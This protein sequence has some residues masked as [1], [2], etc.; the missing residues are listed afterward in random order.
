MSGDALQQ[1]QSSSSLRGSS[2]GGPGAG[3][4]VSA[5]LLLAGD[6]VFFSSHLAALP[7]GRALLG[8]AVV[9]LPVPG[10]VLVGF[11]VVLL[12]LALALL[13]Q[14][15]G[16]AWA[17]VPGL[18]AGLAALLAGGGG[19]VAPAAALAVA[20]RLAAVPGTRGLVLELAVQTAA[21]L[22][23]GGALLAGL[24][25]MTSPRA[26]AATLAHGSARF[27]ADVDL[28]FSDL[29][30]GEGVPLGLRLGHVRKHPI[31]DRS[32]DHV[33]VLM[34]TGAGK[35]SGPM[36][37][38]LLNTDHP[39]L[40]IDPKGELWNLTAGWRAYRGHLAVRFAPQRGA[41]TCCW[42][43][44]AEIEPGDGEVAALSV[45]ADNLITYPAEVHGETH[46]TASARSLLR[47]LVLHVLYTGGRSS[48][49]GATL[50]AV[51]DLLNSSAEG[52]EGLFK[53]LAEAEHDV[54]GSF[55]W[56]DPATGAKTRT[57]PEVARLARAFASTPDRERGSIVSTLNRFLDLWGDPRIAGATSRSDWSLSLLAER[58]RPATVYVTVPTNE[59]GR[60]A[61][62]LRI[63]LALLAQRVT[64]DAE[65][66][67]DREAFPDRPPLLLVLDEFAALGRIPLLEDVLAFFRGYGV[68]VLLAVQDLAQL[69]RLYGPHHTFSA[70]CR[71]HLASA[72]PDVSTRQEISRRLGET[73]YVYRKTSRSGR[74]FSARTMVSQAEVRRPL[75][76]EGEIGALPADR[77]LISKAGYPPVIAEKL[78]YWQ[79]PILARRATLPVPPDVPEEMLVRREGGDGDPEEAE[80]DV[81]GAEEGAAS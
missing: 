25:R 72:T 58:R 14:P 30:S 64:A 81:G 17:P 61:P 31:T 34:T 24:H 39:A 59:L 3:I 1:L 28:R 52:Q 79:H 43:P 40:V 66:F 69:R 5:V 41:D 71:L 60:L 78:G 63:L 23:A 20:V 74:L 50:A 7:Q 16:R 38:T 49:D 68:R 67:H 10:S 75:L 21:L 26:G 47:C 12:L 29:L 80:P 51:R 65:G 22:A 76:T 36:S 45:L 73:T 19:V 18:L 9:A 42:N 33:L 8:D 32:A 4:L 62:L 48:G 6:A 55:G 27:A 35:T 2:H 11:A 57:H 13:A 56:T 54:D 15:G 37:C 46:W 70:T 53:R 44:L 77:I